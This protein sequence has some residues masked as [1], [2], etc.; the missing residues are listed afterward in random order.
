MKVDEKT[1]STL[2]LQSAPAFIEISKCEDVDIVKEELFRKYDVSQDGRLSLS[3]IKMAFD[4]HDFDTGFLDHVNATNQSNFNFKDIDAGL[5]LADIKNTGV[6]PPLL[7]YSDCG[8]QMSPSFTSIT[9]PDDDTTKSTCREMIAKVS[10]AWNYPND[11]QSPGGDNYQ[12][13]YA[14]GRFFKETNGN[15]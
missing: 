7:L 1:L 13:I 10:V 6:T 5:V 2:F 11:S 9:Y 8:V 12:C 4:T 15:R 14:D 3:E